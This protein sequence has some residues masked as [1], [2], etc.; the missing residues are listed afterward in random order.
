MTRD[1]DWMNPH[2]RIPAQDADLIDTGC[3]IDEVLIARED[4]YAREVRR[5]RDGAR[6]DR[7]RLG[8]QGRT[9]R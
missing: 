8:R 5:D 1:R 3:V 4:D 2:T 9:G 6:R 7:R